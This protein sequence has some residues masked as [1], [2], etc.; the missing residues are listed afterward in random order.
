M[1]TFLSPT[2]PKIPLRKLPLRSDDDTI[3]YNYDAYFES[4]FY[5]TRVNPDFWKKSEKLGKGFVSTRRQKE[6]ERE[7]G[8]KGKKDNSIILSFKTLM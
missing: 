8:G 1:V 3:R 2:F 7:R 5:A 4:L 6:R